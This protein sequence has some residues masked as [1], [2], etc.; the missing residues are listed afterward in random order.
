VDHEL[1][2]VEGIVEYGGEVW[3]G[4]QFGGIESLSLMR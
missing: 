3:A 4:R 1:E 2:E